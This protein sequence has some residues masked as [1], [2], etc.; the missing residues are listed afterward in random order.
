[1]VNIL[2]LNDLYYFFINYF[3]YNL[4]YLKEHI[5]GYLSTQIFSFKMKFL[6]VFLL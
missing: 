6:P 2:K 4:F 1:M 3:Y 5:F